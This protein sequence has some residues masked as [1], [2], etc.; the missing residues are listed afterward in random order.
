MIKKI[1]IYIGI[2]CISIGGLLS[3]GSSIFG[4]GMLG[5][6]SKTQ[7][8]AYAHVYKTDDQTFTTAYST[9]TWD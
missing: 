6:T 8:S 5:F 2:T 1:L 4:G 7:I 3:L 9:S